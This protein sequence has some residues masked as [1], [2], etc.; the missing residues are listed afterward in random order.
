MATNV[1]PHF[2]SY[3]PF[4]NLGSNVSDALTLRAR[5][6]ISTVG[7]D[8]AV[9][10]IAGDRTTLNHL[11][12]STWNNVSISGNYNLPEEEGWEFEFFGNKIIAATITTQLQGYA[13]G[14]GASTLFTNL[15]DG[16]LR[17]SARHVA[18]I[19]RFVLIG[20][21]EEGGT[22]FPNRVR[23]SG[24]DDETDFDQAAATLSGS[25]D[26]EGEFGWIQKII[27]G[28]RFGT[29]ICERGIL[30]ITFVGT[31]EV[32][33]ILPVEKQ[34]GTIAPGSVIGWG[35]DIYF[36]DSDGF[37]KW[38]GGAAIP[39]SHGKVSQFFFDNYDSTFVHRI[40]SA[41]DPVNSLVIWGFV[42]TSASGGAP[43]PDRILMYHWP[44]NRWALAEVT[45]EIV[46]TGLSAGVSLEGL[47]S[48]STSIDALTF[49]LDA[50]VYAGGVSQLAAF[51]SSK[52]MAFFDG[53]NLA[54]T[55]ETGRVSLGGTRR[56]LVAGFRPLI[57]G[58]T[59]TGQI[60][61][62]ERLND[63]ETFDSSI[64]QQ[65]SGIIPAKNRARYQ[66]FRASVA[67]SGTWSHAQGIEVYGKGAGG[68]PR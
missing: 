43:D 47:D 63:S 29:L 6:A 8:G 22:R 5:G 21:V 67:A 57:D 62:T 3:R 28:Q 7:D 27:G 37:Y 33:T 61:G 50:S 46:F 65:T 20:N 64:S 36:L 56:S 48:I 15:V 53:S 10:T 54:A 40:T 59:I 23:W 68:R 30:R 41:I 58:G 38:D 18:V 16:T 51:N 60:A 14:A 19:S 4:P 49:S 52:Q 66:K 11:V 39:I 25:Q 42:S 35:R 31:P 24:I 32:F 2:G 34:R 26:I 1:R 13:V 12:G 44:S 55:L 17:P 45:N 9:V